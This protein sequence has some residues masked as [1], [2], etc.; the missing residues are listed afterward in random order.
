MGMVIGVGGRPG[1]RPRPD[2][3]MSNDPTRWLV[4]HADMLPRSGTALD[5]ASGSGRNALWLAARGLETLALDR[6]AIAVE[7]IREAAAQR[8][9]P[10]RAEVLDLESAGA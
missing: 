10:L 9:L 3:S 7:G 2:T 1:D 4:D 8:A 5:V 6:N